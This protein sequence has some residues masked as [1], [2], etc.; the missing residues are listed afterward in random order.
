MTVSL[1]AMT[2]L[3]FTLCNLI[4]TFFQYGNEPGIGID[5]TRAAMLIRIPPYHER[6]SGTTELKSIWEGIKRDPSEYDGYG[7]YDDDDSALSYSSLEE[8]EMDEDSEMDSED[9]E[10]G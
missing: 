1:Q 6:G 5:Y 3:Q 2:S 9:D 8:E 10:D 7:D 4:L